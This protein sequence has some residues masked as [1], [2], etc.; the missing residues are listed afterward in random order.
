M[1][2]LSGTKGYF[3]KKAVE[4]SKNEPYLGKFLANRHICINLD[5]MVC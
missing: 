2:L 4:K 3:A 1:A 5:S